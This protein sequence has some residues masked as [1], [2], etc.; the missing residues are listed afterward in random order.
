[1][2]G[3]KFYGKR[4][5]LSAIKCYTTALDICP[6]TCTERRVTYYR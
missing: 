2:E 4:K 1:V 5:Y 3:N 6:L